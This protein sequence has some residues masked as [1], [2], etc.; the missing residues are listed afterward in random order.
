MVARSW[1][2]V[3]SGSPMATVMGKIVRCQA[4]LKKWSKNSLGNI[5]RTLVDMKKMLSK[6]KAAALQ[7]GQHR[8]FFVIKIRSK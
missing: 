1:A 8:F 5:S 7:G 2:A 4:K 3:Q 6:A